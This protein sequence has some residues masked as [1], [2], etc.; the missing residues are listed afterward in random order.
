MIN[1]PARAISAG[2]VSIPLISAR[3]KAAM[4]HGSKVF[5]PADVPESNASGYPPEFRESQRKRYNQRLGD[6]GGLEN[7]GVNLVRVLPGGQSSAR[8][9]HSMQDEFAY[10]VDGEFVLVTDARREMVGIRDVHRISS[11]HE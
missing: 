8:Y 10:I 4:S 5:R 11:R 7:Y 9:A 6:F 3:Q 2:S 1:A